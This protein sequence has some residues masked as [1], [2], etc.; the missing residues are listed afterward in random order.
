MA[1]VTSLLLLTEPAAAA[2][3]YVGPINV[4][5]ACFAQHH[6]QS[7]ATCSGGRYGWKCTANGLGVNMQEACR[8]Q[9]LQTRGVRALTTGNG[10]NDWGCYYVYNERRSD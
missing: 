1:I 7:E 5:A 9:Y 2:R 6:V 3:R 10:C 8:S 4:R